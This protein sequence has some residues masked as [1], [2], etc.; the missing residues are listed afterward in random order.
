MPRVPVFFENVRRALLE[1]GRIV[2]PFICEVTISNYLNLVQ[3][4][5]CIFIKYDMWSPLVILF[6]GD[7]GV[8]IVSLFL[9]R[10]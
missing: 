6:I 2:T 8:L 10:L 5:K 3:D 4:K 1:N 7:F 9:I